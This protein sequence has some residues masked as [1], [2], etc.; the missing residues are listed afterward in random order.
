LTTFLL[1]T[2]G[3]GQS[4]TAITAITP[5]VLLLQMPQSGDDI[6]FAK[7]GVMEV[8]SGFV[9]NKCDL[10]GADTTHRQLLESLGKQAPVFQT[11]T[12]Q[13]LGFDAVADW[14]TSL[15]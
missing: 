13:R 2:V 14:I 4:D 9:V 5:H 3:I 8:A 1:E 10:P 12:V 6:Q 11:S 7:A 15:T